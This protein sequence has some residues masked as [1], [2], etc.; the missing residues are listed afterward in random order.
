MHPA[1]F[2]ALLVLALIT[3]VHGEE[4]RLIVAAGCFWSIELA[5]QRVPGVVRTSVGYA[6][7]HVPN[8]TYHTVLT[9]TTGHAEAVEVVY[10]PAIVGARRLLDLFWQL[11]DPTS[12]NRQGGDVGSQYRSALFYYTDTQ[13]KA[14]DAS[15][16]ALAEAGRVVTQVA[17]AAAPGFVWAPAEEYHQQYLQKDGQE[18]AKLSLAP[19]QCY[20]RRG[21]IK[22]MDKAGIREILKGEL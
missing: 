9:G 18:S 22:K 8:P 11:H 16:G 1:C 15:R 5:Y 20:G 7:G 3:G 17:S 10:D 21:P 4:E 19:I 2:A 6:G 12:L 13:R 14:I